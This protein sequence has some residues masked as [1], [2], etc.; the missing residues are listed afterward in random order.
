MA[1]PR[2]EGRTPLQRKYS[3]SV[4][5]IQLELLMNKASNSKVDT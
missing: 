4:F 3:G 5:D 2:N 1:L